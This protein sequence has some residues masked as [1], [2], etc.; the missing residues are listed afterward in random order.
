MTGSLF[1]LFF[2]VM[3]KFVLW[4]CYY[5]VSLSLVKDI[6]EIFCIR[7]ATYPLLRDWSNLQLLIA[8]GW[9]SG[10]LSIVAFPRKSALRYAQCPSLRL[11]V[12]HIRVL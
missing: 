4:A 1:K 7:T 6:V 12:R 10:F 8:Q 2:T 3:G 11:S 9:V 5:P